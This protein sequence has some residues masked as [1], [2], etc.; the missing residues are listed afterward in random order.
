M[1]LVVWGLLAVL[2]LRVRTEECPN[3][4]ERNTSDPVLPTAASSPATSAAVSEYAALIRA[5]RPSPVFSEIV[6]LEEAKAVLREAV[7]L[8]A[9]TFGGGLTRLFWRSGE[10]GGVLLVGPSGLGKVAVAEAAAAEAG[11]WVLVLPAAEAAGS[12]FC[13]AALA[14]AASSGRPVVVVVEAFDAAPAASLAIQPCLREATAAAGDGPAPVFVVATMSRDLDH[15]GASALTPFGYIAHLQMPSETDRK[16]F[17]LRLLQ[18]VSRTDP[19]WASALR[20]AAV[21]TLSNLTAN[22]T[23]GEIELLVRRTFIRSTNEEGGRDPVALHHFEQILATMRPRAADAFNDTSVQSFSDREAPGV[24]RKPEGGSTETGK[25]KPRESKD[26]MDGIF[27]WCNCWLP[28]AL[29]LPPVVWAM[30]IF[31]IVA[32]F[33]ARSTYQ[34]YGNRKRR[35]GPGSRNSLFN[36]LGSGSS[37]PYPSFGDSLNDWYPGS[38]SF[39]N[40]PPPPGMRG[41][42][43]S[44]A[45]HLL[46][47]RGGD[48]PG[49]GGS[50]ASNSE[51]TT[52][53]GPE[54]LRP[55]Q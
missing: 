48:M 32:H 39:A 51:P 21:A 35:G 14:T 7:V 23:F 8:P 54:A 52:M 33:M 17:L 27:G 45:S 44:A 30:I 10:R 9:T 36:E 18:Q 19:Q 5:P 34:P 28:E 3:P 53:G 38:G 47:G 2:L 41:G 20:E 40:F 6:G 22:Y 31:G 15:V 46:G 24:A 26:P 1:V 50:H 43:D 42:G 37:N 49:G 13:R 55:P 4:S 12:A 11:A 16:Q 29:H 25:K